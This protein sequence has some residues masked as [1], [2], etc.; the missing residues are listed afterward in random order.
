MEGKNIEM[1]QFILILGLALLTQGLKAQEKKYVPNLTHLIEQTQLSSED[2]N[3]MSLLWWIPKEFWYAALADDPTFTPAGIKEFEDIFKH[4]TVLM[5]VD[6]V[7]GK[8]GNVS[9]TYAQ[10]IHENIE[11]YDEKFN[12]YQPLK[13][14]EIPSDLKEMFAIWQPMFASMLGT[15]GENINY[16]VFQNNYNTEVMDA[17]GTAQYKIKMMGEDYRFRLPLGVLFPPKTCGKCGEEFMG[18]Y[19]FCPYDG[20]KM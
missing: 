7:I 13:E 8:F 6:G 4:F 18:S 9:Y 14:K 1:R 3:K 16:Y 12:V 11:I 20:S 17:S 19:K 15:M 10:K 2:N 5:V